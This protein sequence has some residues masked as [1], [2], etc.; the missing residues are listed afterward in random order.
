MNY[1]AKDTRRVDLV[2][3]VSYEDDI[4]KVKQLIDE[5]LNAEE[6]ILKDPEPTVG[7]AELG[8]SSVNF[9]VRPWVYASDY[10]GVKFCLNET[11]KLRFDQEGIS[12]PYP[13]RD[14]HLR[15]KSAA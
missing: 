8:E 6:R 7:L 4:V 2:F 3:G 13:Q 1:S 10:W 12:I 14:V 15:E 5:V 9:V 11:M